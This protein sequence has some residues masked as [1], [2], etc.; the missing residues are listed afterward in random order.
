MV[1]SLNQWE[2]WLWGWQMTMLLNV[3]AVVTGI[4]LLANPEFR[5]SRFLVALLLGVVATYSFA[6]GIMYW[7]IGLLLLFLA[8]P[9]RKSSV[10][11]WVAAGLITVS[12]YLYD[13]QKP[14]H[15]P[16]IWIILQQ[17]IGYSKY[18]FIYLGASVVNFSMIG[19]F[20]V[21]LLGSIGFWCMIWLLVRRRYRF[22]VLTPY[23]GLS[24]YSIGS[25]LITGIARV[26]FGSAQ[27][28]TSRYMTIS[29]PF[30]FSNIVLLYDFFEYAGMPCIA[31]EYVPGRG[32][33]ELI[34]ENIGLPLSDAVFIF[35]S[36]VNAISYIH[37]N[38]V[39]H[40]DIKPGNIRIGQDGSIKLL[41][42]GIAKDIGGNR[43]TQAGCFVGTLQYLA[44][45]QL[46]GNS[47]DQQSDIWSLGVLF[48]EMLTGKLPFKENSLT[49]FLDDIQ[50]NNFSKSNKR[51]SNVPEDAKNIYVYE[52]KGFAG[53]A[54]NL[55]IFDLTN[56]SGSPNN[57]Q[58]GKAM[59]Y[60]K[61]AMAP[62]INWTVVGAPESWR[63]IIQS[64]LL[65]GDPA[66]KLKAPTSL[67]VPLEIYFLD[68]PLLIMTLLLK[69]IQKNLH[70]RWHQKKR[71]AS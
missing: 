23:V 28:M 49:G 58:L 3:F 61:D 39:L 47:G 26:G 64:C 55:T 40:R 15:H 57:W 59:A 56:N 50:N 51:L 4:I 22:Q 35:K 17:P 12:S 42:F 44:P 43:L 14:P 68:A 27:A 52:D 13:Y 66:Q 7:P 62:T 41:D 69:E 34:N 21:G 6:N 10:A 2:N 5:W 65:F 11:L 30:W 29:S 38:G 37:S 60:S 20:V 33:D 31:M 25:A 9:N 71:G 45:E 19:A 70:K 46:S 32:L 24:L 36:I 18:V 54:N 48:Y 1:F 67:V 53:H 8:S 16:S 63:G